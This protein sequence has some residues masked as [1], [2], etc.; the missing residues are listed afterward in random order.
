M[1]VPVNRHIQV[2]IKKPEQD[3]D[4]FGI[5][6][7]DDYSPKE[8]RYVVASV[9]SCAADVRFHHQIKEGTKVVIDQTMIEKI[10]INNETINIILDN[11][12]VGL[13]E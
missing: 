5:V 3:L 10:T 8:E 9:V 11:Y 4:D 7:P 6:L 13:V 2:E 1:F 12:V